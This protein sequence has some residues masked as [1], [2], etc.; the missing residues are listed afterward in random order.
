MIWLH[1]IDRENMDIEKIN[2]QVTDKLIKII[3]L[4]SPENKKLL[5]RRHSWFCNYEVMMMKF[6]NNRINN[7]KISSYISIL[8]ARKFKI[9]LQNRYG[10]LSNKIITYVRKYKK[11]WNITN[12][13]FDIF[14]KLVSC[15][16]E[17]GEFKMFISLVNDI[18]LSKTLF[19]NSKFGA[20][21]DVIII[22][23]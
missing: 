8:K 22:C 3:R 10:F 20:Y 16:G 5:R 11:M 6:F 4:D 9:L 12:N 21:T 7:F 2:Q 1:E 23:N 18:I 17:D 14:I 13:E 19:S 15:H